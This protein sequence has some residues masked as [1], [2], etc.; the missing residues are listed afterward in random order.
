MMQ[1]SPSAIEKLVQQLIYF[2]LVIASGTNRNCMIFQEHLNMLCFFLLTVEQY[3][4]SISLLSIREKN[5]K[6]SGQ[7]NRHKQIYRAVQSKL[8][9]TNSL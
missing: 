4:F 3:N 5:G 6:V 1:Y 9:A 8:H 2:S 7:A